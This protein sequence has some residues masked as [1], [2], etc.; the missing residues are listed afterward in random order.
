MS[1]RRRWRRRA[2]LTLSRKIRQYLIAFLFI[3]LIPAIIG[4]ASWI[5]SIL[6]D[7]NLTIGNVNISA[8]AILSL[9]MFALT[10]IV[11]IIAI[12]KLGI[13]L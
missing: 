9:L 4:L 10:I 7:R 1:T 5:V 11:F 8:S 13:T 3:I 6:P 2:R 12:R